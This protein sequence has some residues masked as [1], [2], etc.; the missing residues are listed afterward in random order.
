MKFD[1]NGKAYR[2]AKLLDS[3][4]LVC[5]CMVWGDMAG[6]GHIWERDNC[7]EIMCAE[8]NRQDKR[9]DLRVFSHA[10]KAAAAKESEVPRR[11]QMVVWK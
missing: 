5:S 7:I 2:Q 9:L 8:V 6:T 3:Y 1:R 10:Q 11:L 4:G